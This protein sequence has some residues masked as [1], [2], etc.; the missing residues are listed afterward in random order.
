MRSAASAGGR[1]SSARITTRRRP[2][3]ALIVGSPD[4][5][6]EKILFQHEIFG[7]DRFLAQMS[8]GTMPHAKVMRAIELLAPRS[9]PAFAASC[10][11]HCRVEKLVGH[12]RVTTA[13]E[14]G[15]RPDA[16]QPVRTRPIAS[17]P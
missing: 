14:R 10:V 8:V 15:R 11:A 2:R 9:R 1:R 3:G 12:S 17:T 5:V 16:R 13:T 6:V 7:H 4:D